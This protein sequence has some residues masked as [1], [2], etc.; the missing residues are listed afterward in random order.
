MSRDMPT[1]NLLCDASDFDKVHKSTAVAMFHE[2]IPGEPEDVDDHDKT[3][4]STAVGCH[5]KDE[6]DGTASE[7]G[8][9]GGSAGFRHSTKSAFGLKESDL[10]GQ[11][12]KTT[13]PLP[14]RNAGEILAAESRLLRADKKEVNIRDW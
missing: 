4:K 7:K 9:R 6:T 2:K 13:M 5:K 3:H 12:E 1:I 8:D 14:T 11:H 10:F